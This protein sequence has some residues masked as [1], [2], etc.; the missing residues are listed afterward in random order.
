MRF[1]LAWPTWKVFIVTLLWPV[2]LLGLSLWADVDNL[3][4]RTLPTYSIVS[5]FF[6]HRAWPVWLYFVAWLPVTGLLI[7]RLVLPP[8]PREHTRGAV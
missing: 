7:W 6:E 5:V 1:P 3:E 4:A 2:L 8:V